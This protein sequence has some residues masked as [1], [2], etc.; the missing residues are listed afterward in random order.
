[1]DYRRR[2]LVHA[3]KREGVIRLENQGGLFNDQLIIEFF[4]ERTFQIVSNEL[5]FLFVKL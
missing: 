5:S 4:D 1:M 3:Q 2:N